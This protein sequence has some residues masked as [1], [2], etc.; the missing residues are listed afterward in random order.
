[1]IYMFGLPR[2]AS[3]TDLYND[4]FQDKR[5]KIEPKSE[6][7]L[8]DIAMNDVFA[9]AIQQAPSDAASFLQNKSRMHSRHAL[10][11]NE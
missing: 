7:P 5:R 2:F 8:P 9:E 11:R 1:M 4:Q 10:E 3:E 6:Q